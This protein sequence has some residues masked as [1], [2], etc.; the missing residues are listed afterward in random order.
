MNLRYLKERLTGLELRP[1]TRTD[2]QA[3]AAIWC[4]HLSLQ[5]RHRLVDL[6]LPRCRRAGGLTLAD[7]LS[8]H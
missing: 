7:V 3:A 2:C 1:Y 5:E 4:P 8:R 6:L